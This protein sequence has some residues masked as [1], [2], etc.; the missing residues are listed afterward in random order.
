MKY[1]PSKMRSLISMRGCVRP[2]VR[3]TRVEFRRNGIFGLN[4]NK[5]AS[6]TW[7]QA[8]EQIT[9]THLMSE[10]LLLNLNYARK[11]LGSLFFTSV[12][13]SSLF[14]ANSFLMK[15]NFLSPRCNFTSYLVQSKKKKKKKKRKP[16]ASS[17][18]IKIVLNP[19]SP[20]A[21]IQTLPISLTC[22]FFNSHPYPHPY[23]LIPSPNRYPWSSP[24]TVFLTYKVKPRYSAFQGTGRNYTLNQDFYNCQ[25][26]DNYENTSWDQNL[27]A[28]LAESCSKRVR[29][30]GV[31]LY[32][33]QNSFPSAIFFYRYPYP[34]P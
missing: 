13:K 31:S 8:R 21:E 34:Y 24:S 9:R 15:T 14:D 10:F 19:I 22:I 33:F 5:P 4:F 25:H 26:V 2:S 23:S 27:Y 11:L 16:L 7:R 20:S 6:G 30:S 32:S 12:L 17:L 18:P 29:Y 3:H 28:L 1:K